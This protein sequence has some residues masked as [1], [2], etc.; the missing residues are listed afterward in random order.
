MCV[1]T[2]TLYTIDLIKL[3]FLMLEIVIL[4]KICRGP[5]LN[6]RHP[7]LQSGVLPTE[8]PRQLKLEFNMGRTRFELVIPSTSRR[9]HTSRPP[10]QKYI[11]QYL[12]I[13][14]LF[15]I[16][17]TFLSMVAFQLSGLDF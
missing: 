5:D 15:S 8:L 3:F 13:N 10:A 4:F 17:Y 9:Y 16:I 12:F 6:Q 2:N 1:H 11:F 14:Y 7:D